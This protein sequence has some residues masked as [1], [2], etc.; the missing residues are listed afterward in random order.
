MC[1]TT[2]GVPPPNPPRISFEKFL[3][4][5]RFFR[6]YAPDPERGVDL[7][8]RRQAEDAP[9]CATPDLNGACLLQRRGFG[10]VEGHVEPLDTAVV[11]SNGVSLG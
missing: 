7:L 1:T 8:P 2:L 5:I 10:G 11:L 9:W 6:A 3:R 4:T